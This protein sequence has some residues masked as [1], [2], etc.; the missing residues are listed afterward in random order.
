MAGPL[1][2]WANRK[3]K[4]GLSP[5]AKEPPP[6]TLGK[7]WWTE[8][9]TTLPQPEHLEYA[10]QFQLEV[11]RMPHSDKKNALLGHLGAWM[12]AARRLLHEESYN[13]ERADLGTTDGLLIAADDALHE[14][15]TK[16]NKLTNNG[17][18]MSERAMQTQ[19]AL[20]RRTSKLRRDRALESSKTVSQ[21]YWGEHNEWRNG[22]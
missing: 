1:V 8:P 2:W 18:A 7:P 21:P 10:V 20:Q 11:M 19:R 12:R 6:K 5:V 17:R 9:P 22:K 14:A 13:P 15:I 3:S 4:L 16:L